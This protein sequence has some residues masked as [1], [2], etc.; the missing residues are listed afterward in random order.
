[1]P[2]RYY[3][4]AI[5]LKAHVIT[6][7]LTPAV[8]ADPYCARCGAEV[9][10]AC[11]SCGT[12]IRGDSYSEGVVMISGYVTPAP[13]FCFKC[14]NPFP[15]TAERLGAAKELADDLVDLTP[16]Q[17]ER[18]KSAIDDIAVEGPRTEAGAA[19]IKTLIGGATSAVG[20]ALWKMAI[21]IGTEAA[22]KGMLG[23]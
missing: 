15:W 4:A 1:M 16:E 23:S 12:A 2:L 21:D 17:R 3:G 14:G 7:H 6:D 8:K 10:V 18:L 19:R 13:A 9:L 11:L 20:K 5:C 22:K